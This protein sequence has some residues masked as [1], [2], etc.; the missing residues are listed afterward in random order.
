MLT[1]IPRTIITLLITTLL[2]GYNTSAQRT[3]DVGN[4]TLT[5][6][7]VAVNLDVPWEM[8][9]GNDNYIW[10][11]ERGGRVI[12]INP[13]SGN[14]SVILD[15]SDKVYTG[16]EPGLLGM[17]FHPRF[18]DVPLV[19]LVYCQGAFNDTNVKLV[20]YEWTG[21][22]LKNETLLLNAQTN[23]FVFFHYGSR[24]LI[25]NDEKIFMTIGEGG[26]DLVAQNK[27]ELFGKLLRINLDGS[28]PDD[29]P[30]P[31]SYIYSYGHRNAQGL[32]FHPDGR[33][34]STEHG[35]DIADEINI[36]LPNRNYGWPQVEGACN[37]P[38]EIDFCT[39]EN[40]VE[41]IT[42]WT[43]CIAISDIKFYTHEA[44]P[45]WQGKLLM[46]ALGGFSGS[47]PRLSAIELSDDGSTFVSEELYFTDYGRIRDVCINPNNGAIYLATNG[48]SYPGEGPNRII[49]YRN[50]S[51]G[52][53]SVEDNNNSNQYLKITPNLISSSTNC[54]IECSD[55]FVD[56]TLTLYSYNGNIV[57]TVAIHS[58]QQQVDLSDLPSGNYFYTASN[59]KGTISQTIVVQ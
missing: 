29:N 25:S 57:K 28:I 50:L 13:N 17:A 41:P 20:S 27:N 49:E 12:R 36:I 30:I 55:S 3:I 2:L 10:A 48:Q 59:K 44:I 14:T 52:G 47:A 45:E 18:E 6:R 39:Q 5:E 15:I 42:E 53:T 21:Q 56:A 46:A 43:P 38:A 24:L 35:N 23:R 19:Y 51:Y 54:I 34:Y 58:T 1:N 40:V 31:D 9:W 33:I 4:T 7:E 37:T 32:A 22:N 16:G 8:L 11:T 26:N